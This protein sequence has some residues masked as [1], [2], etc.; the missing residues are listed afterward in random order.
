MS[1]GG[2]C[3]ESFVWG[4]FGRGPKTT[5]YSHSTSQTY[6]FILSKMVKGAAAA[7]LLCRHGSTCVS[8]AVCV[9]RLPLRLQCCLEYLEPI[10]NRFFH[11][12][13]SVDPSPYRR[14]REVTTSDSPMASPPTEKIQTVSGT[15]SKAFHSSK[16]WKPAAPFQFSDSDSVTVPLLLTQNKH[17]ISQ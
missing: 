3:C 14:S 17:T 16:A 7:V 10:I 4:R 6:G 5:Q 1:E 12:T 15:V 8:C 9:L 11:N 13:F 2:W